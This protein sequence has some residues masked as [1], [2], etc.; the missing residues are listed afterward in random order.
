MVEMALTSDAVL[1]DVRT[2]DEMSRAP[3]LEGAVPLDVLSDRFDGALE[4]WDRHRPYFLYCDT[5][6]RSRLACTMMAER[7]FVH[8]SYLA[9]GLAAL[10]K[11]RKLS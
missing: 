4:S 3:A 10:P 7:G 6:K 1:F 5:G 11:E 9:G 2:A 8:L